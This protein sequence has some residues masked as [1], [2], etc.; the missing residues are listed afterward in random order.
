MNV[1]HIAIPIRC[2]QLII[3]T[4]VQRRGQLDI[5]VFDASQ[6]VPSF[7]YETYVALQAATTSAANTIQDTATIEKETTKMIMDLQ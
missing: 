1:L 5:S 4:L 7:N 2:L 3:L 6:L